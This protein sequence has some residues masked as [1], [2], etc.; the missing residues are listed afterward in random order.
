MEHLRSSMGE[1]VWQAGMHPDLPTDEKVLDNP[2]T[3]TD[4]RT[5]STH[6]Q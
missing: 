3:Y 1:D 5:A 4:Y 2:Y 6:G